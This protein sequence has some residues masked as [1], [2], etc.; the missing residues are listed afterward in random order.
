M[1][2]CN[3]KHKELL[4]FIKAFNNRITQEVMAD[5]LE[6][7]DHYEFELPFDILLDQLYE[8]NVEISSSEWDELQKYAEVFEYDNKFIMPLAILVV[9]D[10]A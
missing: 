6:Y 5:M 1:S 2:G 9:K 4:K 3:F 8:N 10:N 7:F